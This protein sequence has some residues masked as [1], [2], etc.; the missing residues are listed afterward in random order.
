MVREVVELVDIVPVPD[1]VPF[2][3]GV[4]SLRGAILAVVD[5]EKLLFEKTT[6][7]A[8]KLIILVREER[9]IAALTVERV[10]GVF[11]L[12]GS[13][14]L[15]S[16]TTEKFLSDVHDLQLGTLVSKIDVPELM[17]HLDASRPTTHSIEV[18]E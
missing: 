13:T 10:E 14:K 18:A 2:V 5:S 9:V 8:S 3:V 6:A 16:S 1:T 7:T 15:S 11:V 17:H 4:T 12:H